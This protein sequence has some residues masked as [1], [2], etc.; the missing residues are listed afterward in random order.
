MKYDIFISYRRD[1]GYDTA[2][3]LYDLLIRDGY[4][5]S[6]DIDTLRSGDFDVQLLTRIEQCKDFIL[7][8]DAHAFDRTLD[9]SFDPS[10]DWLRCELAHA[11]KLNKNIIPVFLAGVSG[12]PED[13]PADVVGVVKKNGPEYNKYYFNNFY[14]TLKYK[15][16]KSWSIKKKV[17]VALIPLIICTL[18]VFPFLYPYIISKESA[19][20]PVEEPDIVFWQNPLDPH[21]T[22]EKELREF[23]IS[24]L[25]EVAPS[26]IGGDPYYTNDAFHYWNSLNDAN[27]QLNVGLCYLVGYG[28]DVDKT[29][30]IEYISDAANNESV[31]AQYVLGVCYYNGIG[32]PKNLTHAEQWLENAAD[33]GK[34]VEA[35]CDYGIFLAII[36]NTNRA[37]QYLMWSSEGCYAKA[38]Y[39]IGYFYGNS[40][41]LNEFYKYMQMA[42][43]QGY[44]YADMAM[45]SL[46]SNMYRANNYFDII[47]IDIDT[48]L[49]RLTSYM[50]SEIDQVKY[51]LAE[52]YYSTADMNKSFELLCE[53]VRLGHPKAM[54]DLAL[55]YVNDH[56]CCDYDSKK[57]MELFHQSA[58]LGYTQAMDKLGQIY[59]KGLLGVTKN[60]QE[61]EKWHKMVSKDIIYQQNKQ[62]QQFMQA[63]QYS[64]Q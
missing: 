28:C 35:R 46:Y 20:T 57:A 2:K 50:G 37:G 44:I 33:G 55:F 41:N 9:P 3:H 5:V 22:N 58:E 51:I 11:L 45:L 61:A 6:F 27:S 49:E 54:H 16:L 8:V 19:P 17:L 63:Q 29:K 64:Q 14:K 48:I 1:G 38:H 52:Y 13:L 31:F 62:L 24:H 12:F 53:S 21:V 56:P 40:G 39:V 10:K 15:F 7:I 4:K 59:E 34:I 25:D 43:D 30:A 32:V 60:P 47:D 26:Q 23:L 36:Y 18:V 42:A